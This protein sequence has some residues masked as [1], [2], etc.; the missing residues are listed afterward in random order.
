MGGVRTK[1]ERKLRGEIEKYGIR[2]GVITSQEK[3]E[4]F[5]SKFGII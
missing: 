5:P 3:G 2:K 1:L 4:R